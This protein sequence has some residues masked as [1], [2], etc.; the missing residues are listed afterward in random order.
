MLGMV[1][2]MLKILNQ[3]KE[4]S[5]I[6]THCV[7]VWMHKSYQWEIMVDLRFPQPSQLC[8]TQHLQNICWARQW[9]QHVCRCCLG[10]ASNPHAF[11]YVRKHH[12]MFYYTYLPLQ[13]TKNTKNKDVNS[14]NEIALRSLWKKI[15]LRK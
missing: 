7:H 13:W 4:M 11:I 15:Y 9:L 12:V 6:K 1:H 10:M 3:A 8:I 2:K 5:V 14:K